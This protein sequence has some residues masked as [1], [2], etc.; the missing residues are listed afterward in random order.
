MTDWRFYIMDKRYAVLIDADNVSEK[1]IKPILDEIS[2]EGVITYK[3]IYGD[4]TR[5]ALASWKQALLNHNSAVQLHHGEKL[6]R[7][8]HDNRRYGYSLFP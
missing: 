7:F 4:W 2:N 8:R 1:Y 6:Y 5:P 3:R